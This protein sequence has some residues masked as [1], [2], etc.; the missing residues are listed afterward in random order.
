M[1]IQLVLNKTCHV[2]RISI[3]VERFAR[4][5]P[6]SAWIMGMPGCVGNPSIESL[7]WLICCAMELLAWMRNPGENMIPNLMRNFC[8]WTWRAPKLTENPWR[9]NGWNI[10]MEV[11][12]KGHVLWVLWGGDGWKFPAF[13]ICKRELFFSVPQLFSQPTVEVCMRRCIDSTLSY[14]ECCFFSTA[15]DA[16][17]FIISHRCWY[18]KHLPLFF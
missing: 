15:G 5:F 12:W 6:K 1:E 4:V 3:G 16:D 17:A 10:L 2:L 11:W 13:F 8:W 18:N 7:S 9:F 14:L